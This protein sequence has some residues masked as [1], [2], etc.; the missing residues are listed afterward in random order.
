MTYTYLRSIADTLNGDRKERASDRIRELSLRTDLYTQENYDMLP[1]I[2][3]QFVNNE[4]NQK[5]GSDC[6]NYLETREFDTAI[7]LITVPSI[8]IHGDVDPRPHKYV[9][10]LAN[11][12]HNSKFTLIPNAGHY[13][14]IDNPSALRIIIIEFL[15]KH[16]LEI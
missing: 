11:K 5:V 14:W 9:N 10:E 16:V 12:L 3:G 13:P 2:Y 1:R 6:N 8:F 15:E 4:V 7:S